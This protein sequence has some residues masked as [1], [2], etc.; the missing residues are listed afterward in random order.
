M[1]IE[2]N[3]IRLSFCFVFWTNILGRIFFLSVIFRVI[4]SWEIEI[5]FKTVFLD[6]QTF[7]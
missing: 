3:I 6:V 4:S 7:F 5:R 2:F 1:E